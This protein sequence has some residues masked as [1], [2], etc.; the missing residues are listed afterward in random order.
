MKGFS[1]W[2][3]PANAEFAQLK[4][5]IQTHQIASYDGS[6][7]GSSGFDGGGA[8]TNDCV[9]GSKRC[10]SNDLYQD[11]G[12]YDADPCT[13][14]SP[15]YSCGT[16][17]PGTTCSNGYCVGSSGTD[18]GTC[19][20]ACTQGAKRC[21]DVDLYQDCGNFDSD[22]CTEWSPNY[23][24][25]TSY[26]GTTC[27]NGYCVG[28]S[29]ECTAGSTQCT[30]ATHRQVCGNFD[31]D[32]CTE[33]GPSTACASGQT[34]ASGQCVTGADAGVLDGGARDGGALDDGALDAGRSDA[35]SVN[36]G[37]PGG[38]SGAGGGSGSGAGGSA[39]G[40]GGGAGAQSGCG[41]STFPVSSVVL[42]AGVGLPM[43][44][45]RRRVR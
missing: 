12:N 27:S 10:I 36:A 4:T 9:Q 18:A 15:S 35:G 14:W 38:G 20:N 13:E 3:T 42:I 33:W 28:C 26:P 32:T 24:C 21:I 30:D 25:S 16:S 45:R 39:S 43:I 11:C 29:N 22:S 5:V 6:D 41:C 2:R 44:R 19:T 31:A 7:G 34:C 37:G 40:T 8:C 17:Y 23:S 1:I